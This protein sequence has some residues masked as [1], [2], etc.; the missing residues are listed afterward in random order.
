[1]ARF[2]MANIGSSMP[3]KF[4][5]LSSESDDASHELQFNQKMKVDS[6]LLIVAGITNEAKNLRPSDEKFAQISGTPKNL[7]SHVLE[8]I[9]AWY[10]TFCYSGKPTEIFKDQE[11]IQAAYHKKPHHVLNAAIVTAEYYPD[12][13]EAILWT[14]PCEQIDLNTDMTFRG[15][16][17]SPLNQAIALATLGYGQALVMLLKYAKKHNIELKGVDLKHVG[18][19]LRMMY[20]NATSSVYAE[21][22]QYF[23]NNKYF[24]S[25]DYT[26]V[27]KTTN[28]RFEQSYML[29]WIINCATLGYPKI[30]HSLF[31]QST[32]LRDALRDC[33]Q[34]TEHSAKLLANRLFLQLALCYHSPKI[35]PEMK[36][37]IEDDL[38][39]LHL[40]IEHVASLSAPIF[41]AVFAD[42]AKSVTIMCEDAKKKGTLA[43]L[44][45]LSMEKK[46]P[47]QHA[48]EYRRFECALVLLNYTL[49][50]DKEK[51]IN[52][53]ID[54]NWSLLHSFAANGFAK[55][56]EA[57]IALG[58]DP[59][60]VAS[61]KQTALDVAIKRSFSGNE[62]GKYTQTIRALLSHGVKVDIQEN[63]AMTSL[64]VFIYHCLQW[65]NVLPMLTKQYKES[66]KVF[67]L[68]ESPAIFNQ[69]ILQ[70]LISHYPKLAPKDME[71]DGILPQSFDFMVQDNAQRPVFDLADGLFNINVQSLIHQVQE[72]NQHFIDKTFALFEMFKRIQEKDE[73]V[74]IPTQ[75][76]SKILGYDTAIF[77]CRSESEI[78]T[79]VK[80]L[81]HAWNK[82]EKRIVSFT[83]ENATLNLNEKRP[84][85]RRKI[86]LVNL[87]MK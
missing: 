85:K 35:L 84:Q 58:A 86:S 67:T 54:K 47:L 65:H 71:I 48:V 39:H 76:V 36:Q 82:K 3:P 45:N 8:C 33:L 12:F 6:F 38:H 4:S 40:E 7:N 21:M 51:S 53:L 29:G 15:E 69:D 10:T 17:I 34:S 60:I 64:G 83:E 79:Q 50:I 46:T 44:M 57:L 72:T 26:A 19:L 30:L 78:Q 43:A 75:L 66:L 56:V 87:G 22:M 77:Q 37:Y 42:D 13:L 52:M 61:D 9:G 49:A 25:L 16:N 2:I 27:I 55:G 59:N 24:N 63:R 68:V 20:T 31:A 70:L 73:A 80:G 5:H 32:V 11:I 23:N 1:M 41:S 81:F 28:D 14:I 74:V 18:W 62:R